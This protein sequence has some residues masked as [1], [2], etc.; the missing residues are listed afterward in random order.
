[1]RTIIPILLC[2]VA[3]GQK[4]PPFEPISPE[5]LTVERA[6]QLQLEA[7]CRFNADCTKVETY[8][9]CLA[10]RIERR[11]GCR[12]DDELARRC[13]ERWR[14]AKCIDGLEGDDWT[15]FHEHRAEILGPDPDP[16]R[17]AFYDCPQ[18][19]KASLDVPSS[20][21]DDG[22]VLA[23]HV[24]F[25]G[26]HLAVDGVKVVDTE[27]ADGVV[28]FPTRY[29]SGSLITP[30]HS[31]MEQKLEGQREI[32]MRTGRALDAIYALAVARDVP[33]ELVNPILHTA[34]KAGFERIGVDVA[35]PLP[36]H[37]GMMAMYTV[38]A[39]P[40]VPFPLPSADRA[41]AYCATV[42]IR[43]D[44]Y[45]VVRHQRRT[46][47]LSSPTS[48]AE[49][50]VG[51]REETVLPCDGDGCTAPD[52]YDAAGLTAQMVQAK[53]TCPDCEQVLIMVEPTILWEVVVRT[54]DAT[55]EGGDAPL[56][57]RPQLSRSL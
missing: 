32:A 56:F 6:D 30:L 44:G 57:P 26:T 13:I 15:F 21:A 1:V 8:E 4:T 45:E 35:A 22:Y 25:D 53:E 29:T 10:I 23:P 11:A 42:V 52:A 54:L 51:A 16:C 24:T 55:R 19:W 38:A 48:S 40:A 50:P 12:V 27:R 20:T 17:D 43:P 2:L 33:F 39:W 36:Q 31:E 41:D 3:C 18:W 28:R 34:S 49:Q 7:V 5:P 37:D 14:D 9:E 47:L 46:S